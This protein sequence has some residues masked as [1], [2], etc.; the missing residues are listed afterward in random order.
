MQQPANNP[1]LSALAASPQA[2]EA[3]H[4]AGET[5]GPLFLLDPQQD[6]HAIAPLLDAFATMDVASAAE[7]WPARNKASVKNALAALQAGALQALGSPNGSDALTWE[8]R[9]LF[10]GPGPKAAPPWGSV[11]TD[12]ECVVFGQA[13]LEL[14]S[15]MRSEGIA[16][17]GS[18]AEPE[19]HIGLML[20]LMAWIAQNR[21]AA[22]PPFLA[23]HLMPWA[24]HFLQGMERAAEHPFYRGLAQL[25]LASLTQL[26]ASLQLNVTEPRFYR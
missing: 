7:E 11:Y 24:P 9:R 6:A 1:S 8:F 16:R 26:S 22:L 18:T 14:R 25:T 12:K 20:S 13:T 17:L 21:P 19:D 3:A 23:L 15:W 5:L 2:L 4:F 10:V